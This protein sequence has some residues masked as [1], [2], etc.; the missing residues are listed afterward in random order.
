MGLGNDVCVMCTGRGG[1]S[2]GKAGLLS[3]TG[4]AAQDHIRSGTRGVS[5]C[6]LGRPL[7]GPS[8]AVPLDRRVPLFWEIR[9]PSQSRCTVLS[10]VDQRGGRGPSEALNCHNND[11]QILRLSSPLGCFLYY[12]CRIVTS[13]SAPR[14]ASQSPLLLISARTPG[15]VL[16][17]FETAASPYRQCQIGQTE[18]LHAYQQLR[19]LQPDRIQPGSVHPRGLLLMCHPDPS[20]IHSTNNRCL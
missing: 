2:H 12:S 10:R 15:V 16:F 1:T 17:E 5:I 18:R 9:W 6:D 20:S 19:Y 7:K 3:G 14:P 4:S 11:A 8:V 13:F